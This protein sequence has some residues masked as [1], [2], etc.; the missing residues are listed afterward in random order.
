MSSEK[1]TEAE[2]VFSNFDSQLKSKA[3]F[4]E[5]LEDF[6]NLNHIEIA[7]KYGV[8]KGVVSRIFVKVFK[9]VF[10]SLYP[11]L[12]PVSVKTHLRYEKLSLDLPDSEPTKTIALK[13]QEQGLKVR[14]VFKKHPDYVS[15]L[16]E[17]KF[18]L[19]ATFPSFIEEQRY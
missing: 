17:N 11:H 1:F 9:P 16:Y 5:L 14:R 7:K 8:T 15:K 10:K 2:L 6:K 4:N 18:K 12:N 19:Y 3:T 13:A